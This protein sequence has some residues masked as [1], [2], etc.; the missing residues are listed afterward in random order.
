MNPSEPWPCR[1]LGFICVILPE[2]IGKNNPAIDIIDRMGS[3]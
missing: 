3:E 2:K 1:G